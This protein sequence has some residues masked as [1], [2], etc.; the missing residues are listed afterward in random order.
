MESLDVLKHDFYILQR[1]GGAGVEIAELPVGL[2]K[3][4]A[5]G[6]I[7]P[8]G[9][10]LD[11]AQAA[12]ARP[13]EGGNDDAAALQG[14]QQRFAGPGADLTSTLDRYGERCVLSDMGRPSGITGDVR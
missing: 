13:A 2:A 6:L 12:L 7:D 9:D 14:I 8:A 3:Q 10:E 11:A 4:D 5:R 1:I